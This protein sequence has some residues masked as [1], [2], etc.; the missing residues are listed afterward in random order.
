MLNTHTFKVSYNNLILK[1]NSSSL[2]CW[3]GISLYINIMSM[4]FFSEYLTINCTLGIDMTNK[5]C[6]HQILP[7]IM[8]I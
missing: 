4:D 3:L 2:Q 6:R 8:N 1:C 5:Y 7:Y